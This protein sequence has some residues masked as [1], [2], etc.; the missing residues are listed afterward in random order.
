VAGDVPK[1]DSVGSLVSCVIRL[2]LTGSAKVH[3]TQFCLKERRLKLKRAKHYPLRLAPPTRWITRHFSCHVDNYSGYYSL[4]NMPLPAARYMLGRPGCTGVAA[5]L[6]ERLS[7]RWAFAS[8]QQERLVS[9]IGYGTIESTGDGASGM[10]RP[11][12]K[13]RAE[14]ATRDDTAAGEG[15]HSR[16][17]SFPFYSSL[18]NCRALQIYDWGVGHPR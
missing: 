8:S 5:L 15:S 6:S 7:R 2:C 13:S 1:G 16:A 12:S 10:W 11:A 18:E 9:A 4:R 3:G 17:S 14:T